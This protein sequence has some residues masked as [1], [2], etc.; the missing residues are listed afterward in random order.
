MALHQFHSAQPLHGS[1]GHATRAG[2]T[3]QQAE[4]WHYDFANYGFPQPPKFEDKLEEREYLKGRLAAAFRIFGQMGFDEGVAGH[5]T[6]R[7]SW[8]RTGLKRLVMFNNRRIL[9]SLTPCG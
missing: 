6:V 3:E 1:V 9:W 5:I 7:V 8:S 4:P 2:S